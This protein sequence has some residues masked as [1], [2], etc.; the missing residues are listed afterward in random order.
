ML[1]PLSWNA[2]RFNRVIISCMKVKY[3]KNEALCKSQT[4]FETSIIQSSCIPHQ[5][6]LCYEHSSQVPMSGDGRFDPIAQVHS[7]IIIRIFWCSM[8][9]R[10]IYRNPLAEQR[11]ISQLD[12]LKRIISFGRLSSQPI[13]ECIDMNT[14]NWLSKFPSS[15][16]FIHDPRSRCCRRP[17]E[18][19]YNLLVL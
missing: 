12:F 18:D 8:R 17:N 4:S 2:F 6:H 7:Y 15:L 19:N 10:C 11:A 16:N 3:F 13:F 5:K 9:P 1:Q 14:H